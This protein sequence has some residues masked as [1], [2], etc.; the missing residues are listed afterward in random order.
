LIRKIVA[1]EVKLMKDE[2][3]KKFCKAQA[4]AVGVVDKAPP[5]LDT[6]ILSGS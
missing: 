5:C 2:R 3:F 4:P 6:G 1:I